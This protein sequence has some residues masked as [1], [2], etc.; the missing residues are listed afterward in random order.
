[1]KN[2]II[3]NI[4]SYENRFDK[5]PENSDYKTLENLGLPHEDS[6]VYLDY[7]KIKKF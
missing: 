1:L 5:L 3:Q 6:R 7:K 2:K 4:K